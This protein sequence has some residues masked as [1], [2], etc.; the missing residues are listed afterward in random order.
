MTRCSRSDESSCEITVSFE[1]G[2]DQ[3]GTGT[4]GFWKNHQDAWPVDEITIGG[5]T[6]TKSQAIRIMK[7]PVRRDKTRNMFNDL[8]CAKL[9]V[10][11]GTDPSCISDTIVAA[12]EW[13]AT[14]GPVGSGVTADSDAWK[15]G[16][17]LHL[18]LDDY[19]NGK[20]CAPH[21]D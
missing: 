9:N 2:F 17:P 21:R 12:D 16:E 18:M 15:I 11:I 5:V 6:Y 1:G 7:R 20:L 3:P 4:P 13:M 14:Y 10:M 8:V 19:N